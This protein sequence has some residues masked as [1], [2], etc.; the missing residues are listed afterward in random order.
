VRFHLFEGEF[1]VFYRIMHQ[2]DLTEATY[3]DF[4]FYNV[5]LHFFI[6]VYSFWFLQ[7]TLLKVWILIR[8][9]LK[10]ENFFRI[11]VELNL[12][13]INFPWKKEI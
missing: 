1:F 12:T 8:I 5:L 10:I 6:L 2:V 11:K 9:L 4:L 3:T 13:L 7:H